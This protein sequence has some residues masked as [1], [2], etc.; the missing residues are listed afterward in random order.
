MGV[1]YAP[2]DE[3]L[4]VVTSKVQEANVV[5]DL[6]PGIPSLPFVKNAYLH[7][8]LNAHKPSIQRMESVARIFWLVFPCHVVY[9]RRITG[10]AVFTLGGRWQ[11]DARP[12]TRR[13][14]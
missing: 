7:I 14:E 1:T 11:G 9:Q 2:G 12:D 6:G 13:G 10:G 5:L 3:A 8:C 4:D